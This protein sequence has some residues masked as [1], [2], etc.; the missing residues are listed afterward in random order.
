MEMYYIKPM[1]QIEQL[2]DWFTDTKVFSLA[3]GAAIEDQDQIKN[4][5][6][7]WLYYLCRMK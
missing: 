6:D 2:K 7:I 1:A 4:S 3:T 5:G